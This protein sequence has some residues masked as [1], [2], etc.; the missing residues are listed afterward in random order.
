MTA[1]V[2]RLLGE[3]LGL[4]ETHPKERKGTRQWLLL[5][6]RPW[7]FSITSQYQKKLK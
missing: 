6:Y 4:A 3:F 7:T 2:N 1:K 5:A